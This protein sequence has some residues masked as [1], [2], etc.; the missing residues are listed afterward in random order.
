MSKTG[1]RTFLNNVHPQLRILLPNG[2]YATFLGGKLEVSEDDPFLDH[3]TRVAEAD[4]STIV[5]TG[6]VQCLAC[7]AEF[8]GKSAE[9][10]LG[11][12]M[13]SAH[14]E[15][16]AAKAVDR[17]T[18]QINVELR[19]RETFACDACPNPRM[20]VFGSEDDLAAHVAAVHTAPPAL[21][22]EGNETGGGGNA[23]ATPPAE[24]PAARPS[25][26]G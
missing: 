3:I 17:L 13:A 4:P 20:S 6:G 21:D 10:E 22:D 11:A 18:A 14:P 26:R 15:I 19:G 8:T 7:G 9:K 16:V 5:L 1:T 24:V 12:H 25:R 2:D 23:A